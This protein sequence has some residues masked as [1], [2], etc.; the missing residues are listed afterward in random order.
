MDILSHLLISNLV[1]KELPMADRWLALV[2]GVFPDLA[3]FVGVFNI[4]FAKKLL[5]FKRIPA[6]YF[7]RYVLLAYNITHSLLFWL[8]TWMFFYLILHWTTAAIIVSSWGLHIVIDIFTH[9]SKSN[10]AAR[11]FWPVSNWHF[12]GFMY[13]TKKFL[14]SAYIIIALLY[15]IFYF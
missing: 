11:I 5:F 7:P 4:E 8:A 6:A 15:L 3:S 2:M 12:D 13:T 14:I 10:L 9:N 1:Y